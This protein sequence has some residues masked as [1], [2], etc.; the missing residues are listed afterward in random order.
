MHAV[1][2]THMYNIH[3]HTHAHTC[4]RTYTHTHTK[5]ARGVPGERPEAPWFYSP[6]H[7]PSLCEHKV[8]NPLSHLEVFVEAGTYFMVT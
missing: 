3:T 2:Y 7:A 6:K 4:I 1:Y 8:G 5:N